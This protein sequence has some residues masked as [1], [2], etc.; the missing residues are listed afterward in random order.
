MPYFAGL[1]SYV[2]CKEITGVNANKRISRTFQASPEPHVPMYHISQMLAVVKCYLGMIM[3]SGGHSGRFAFD[4]CISWGAT[5][6][7]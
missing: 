2:H 7:I 6:Q 5:K 3:K 4:T 1:I